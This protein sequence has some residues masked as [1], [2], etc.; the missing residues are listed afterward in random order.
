MLYTCK[1]QLSDQ[2]LV[3]QRFHLKMWVFLEYFPSTG[4]NILDRDSGQRDRRR[5]RVHLGW[6]TVWEHTQ[7]TSCLSDLQFLDKNNTVSSYL[8]FWPVLRLSGH[9]GLVL[10]NIQDCHGNK[11]H[12]ISRLDTAQSHHRLAWTAVCSVTHCQ[13][14]H[15]HCQQDV[16][17]N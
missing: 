13:Q 3:C 15:R 2:R 4:R 10:R 11:A 16:G 8:I 17:I 14:Q 1:V 6:A 12:S 7:C 5:E 9:L